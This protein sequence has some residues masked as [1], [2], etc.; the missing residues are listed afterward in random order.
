MHESPINAKQD[1]AESTMKQCCLTD[2]ETTKTN[3]VKTDCESA[4][5]PVKGILKNYPEEG[6]MHAT[7]GRQE[8]ADNQK[9]TACYL[10][11]PED[12][13]MAQKVKKRNAVASSDS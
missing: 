13:L 12:A 4:G 6:K 10:P 1:C 5:K 2:Q 11:Q 7:A 8:P 9:S 3:N